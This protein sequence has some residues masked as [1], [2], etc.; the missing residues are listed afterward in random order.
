M[1]TYESE[2][3]LSLLLILMHRKKL[4]SP[5][6]HA[7]NSIYPEGRIKELFENLLRH[8]SSSEKKW[9]YQ[10]TRMSETKIAQR[11]CIA[12][13]YAPSLYSSTLNLTYFTKL[14]IYICEKWMGKG[15]RITRN[16]RILG[17][18]NRPWP[19]DLQSYIF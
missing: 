13:V 10:A 14:E 5:N 15:F 6:T 18:Q 17:S 7:Y 4:Q 16:S 11:K 2:F 19:Q 1:N 3:S 8:R 9:K 12:G